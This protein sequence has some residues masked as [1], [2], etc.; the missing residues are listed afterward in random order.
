MVY[1]RRPW[2]F[3]KLYI[4]VSVAWVIFCW[5]IF[6]NSGVSTISTVITV[7]IVGIWGIAWLIRLLVYFWR[8]G[9]RGPQKTLFYWL[10]EPTVIVVSLLL[11]YA[12]V[13]SFIRFTLSEQALTRYVEDV[14]TG[15]VNIA[16]K[17]NHPPRKIGLYTVSQTDLMP[18]GTVRV[19]TSL[20]GLLDKAGFANSSHNPP[21]RRGE[22]TYKHI[23]QQWWYWHESW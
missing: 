10:F 13:F 22:D 20:H 3:F 2:M 19:I 15:K 5:I 23:Y 7:Y 8:K 11:S 21:P 9:N 1:R 14:R 12:G 18:D 4:L 16:F 6:S 17:F